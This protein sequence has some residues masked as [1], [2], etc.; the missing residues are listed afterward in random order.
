MYLENSEQ[1]KIS[2]KGEHSTEAML[3]EQFQ[4]P[5]S[6]EAADLLSPSKRDAEP[7]IEA[8]LEYPQQTVCREIEPS[9]LCVENCTMNRDETESCTYCNGH[10]ESF[11]QCSACDGFYKSDQIVLKYETSGLTQPFCESAQHC[12]CFKP[13]KSSERSANHGLACKCN[14]CCRQS[15]EH[16]QL[17]QQC[18]PSDQQFDFESDES[19]LNCDRFEQC[20]MSD[21]IP[22]C[23]EQ[24]E[25]PHQYEPSD[26]QCVCFDCEPATSTKDS[27]QCEMTGFAPNLSD[28][29][30]TLDTDLCDE[31]IQNQSDSI[32]QNEIEPI[33]RE[34]VRL[35]FSHFNTPAH[36][37]CD[38]SEDVSFASKCCEKDSLMEGNYQQTNVSYDCSE[39]C[40]ECE[41]NQQCNTS[42]QCSSEKTSDFFTEEDSFSDC[43]ST[44]TKSFKTCPEGSI[45]SD[46]CSDSSGESEKGAQ[47]DSSDEQTEWESFEDEEIEQSNINGGIEDKKKMPT[48]DIG[49][50][51][52]FDPFDRADYYGHTFAQKRHYISCFDGGDVHA[53][54]YL[55]EVHSE[56]QKLTKNVYKHKQIN[57]EACDGT[58]DKNLSPRDDA[59][60]GSWESEK[61]PN[62]WIGESDSNLAEDEAE[63][64]QV[65]ED[66]G[67]FEGKACVFYVH[68]SEIC[69]EK[70][71][72]LSKGNGENL[73]A[74]FANDISVEGDA[75]EDEVSYDHKKDS[76]GDNTSTFGHLQT[77]VTVCKKEDK[78]ESDQEEFIAC[79]EMEP[80]WSHEENEEMYEPGVEE[81]YA[82]QIKCIIFSNKQNLNEFIKKSRPYDQITHRKAKEDPSEKDALLSRKETGLQA[83]AQ[84]SP[85]EC[86]ADTFG[87][88]QVIELSENL[89]DSFIVEKTNQLESDVDESSE[90]SKESNPPSDVIHSVVSELVKSEGKDAYTKASEQGG[91]SEEEQSDDESSE[92][93][94]CEYCLPPIEQVLYSMSICLS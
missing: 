24:L 7:D 55:E 82:Y 67:T 8:L 18:K 75:Y 31:E 1:G 77:T 20:V 52:F 12:E 87:I 32:E 46:P 5:E 51:D 72:S 34:F 2:G 88:S 89:T 66:V 43:S 28:S 84:S 41:L 44:E 57:K 42:E 13:C 85:E 48:L 68:V 21:F 6:T 54:L 25:L 76:N 4:L 71:L 10:S 81:Y 62:Y 47:E 38:D 69:D 37:Y 59:S 27:E 3:T 80:Y 36:V 40:Q 9:L 23:T 17:F 56:G 50:E 35:N 93:C 15:V 39:I 73:C 92:S 91:D 86:K 58:Y 16:L 53:H 79:S 14:P 45:P 74:A 70:S 29:V 90:T 63:F 33:D 26:Q 19:E 11:K 65:E 94:E 30:D 78:D 22:E 49:I 61:Q 83:H 64:E 60:S